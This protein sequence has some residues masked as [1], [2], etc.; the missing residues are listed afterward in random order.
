MLYTFGY[1]NR[2]GYSELANYIEANKINFLI[3]VRL[4]PYG[5]NA[6]WH[7]TELEKFCQQRNVHYHSLK[8]LGNTINSP[9]WKPLDEKRAVN[10]LHGIARLLLNEGNHILLMCSEL[11]HN[12]CH[13][14][15]VATRINQL[16][17]KP[18]PIEHLK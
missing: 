16:L 3:D 5:W 9:N 14:T 4:T 1:G 8:E 6:I 10:T 11:D 18:V 17:I 7:H 15:Q 13:R 2:K 12:R